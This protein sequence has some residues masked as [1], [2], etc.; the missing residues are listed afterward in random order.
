MHHEHHQPLR[1]VKSIGSVSASSKIGRSRRS[2]TVILPETGQKVQKVYSYFETTPDER[3]LEERLMASRSTTSP[4]P[5]LSEASLRSPYQRFIRYLS[6]PV[7]KGDLKASF[8]Y[9]I[10]SLAVYNRTISDLLGVSDSKHLVCTTVVYFH[11]TRTKGSMI[12]SLIFVC[13]SLGFA[14]TVSVIATYISSLFLT[15]T[16]NFDTEVGDF[17]QLIISCASLGAISFVKLWMNQQT[18]DN[19]CSLS[20]ITVIACIIKEGS[21]GSSGLPWAKI[22]SIFL[23]TLT[24]CV[25][26][27]GTN[28]LL[29]PTSAETN[30]KNS[31]NEN[32]DMLSVLLKRVSQSFLR[33]EN[34]DSPAMNRLVDQHKLNLISLKETLLEAKFELYLTGREYEYQLLE[35][36]VQSANRLAMIRAGLR[37]SVD[38]KWELV[39]QEEAAAESST[40]GAVSIKSFQ[41]D[42]YNDMV[43]LDDNSSE[44][45]IEEDEDDYDDDVVAFDSKELFDL[46]VYHLGPSMKSFSFT[47]R[48]ILASIAFDEKHNVVSLV[49]QFTESLK[50]ARELFDTRQ[51]KAI[52]NLYD[53]ELFKQQTDFDTKLHQE[54]VTASCG[55]FTYLL[56]EFSREL[57]DNLAILNE[58]SK[59]SSH[60]RTF[61]FLKFWDRKKRKNPESTFNGML[62]H[63]QIQQDFSPLSTTL[64]TEE[65]THTFLTACKRKI[66]QIYRLFYGVDVQFGIRVFFGTLVMAIFGYLDSTKE[67]FNG[68]HSE[69]GIVAFCIIMNKS[70]GGTYMT[71][72]WRFFGTFIGAMAGY[73]TWV[74]FYPNRFMMALC[75]FLFALP[76]FHIIL[77]WTYI[78]GYGRFILLAYNLTILYSYTR[79]IG[80]SPDT[81]EGGN[82]PMVFQIGLHRFVG[83]SLGSLWALIVTMTLFPCSARSR[84]RRGLSILWLRMGIVW[85]SG[86]LSYVVDPD[87]RNCKLI[88]IRDRKTIHD[89]MDELSILLT[90]APLE[91]RLKGPFPTEIYSKLLKST[92]KIIDAFENMNS[93]IQ[94]DTILCPNEYSVLAILHDEV[95]E[96]ENRVFLIFYMLAS[97]MKLGFP[98]ANK[99]ASTEH[100]KKRM[101]LKLSE[102]R[103]RI[104]SENPVLTN[105]DF[106]L[107]YSYNLVTN[108][109]IKELDVLL[110]LVAELYGMVSEDTLAM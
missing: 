61:G 35:K 56:L 34:L 3:G 82:D 29:W 81:I 103:N 23:I 1:T 109:V 50:A 73:L 55:N 38:F 90:Q 17:I 10:A 21:V 77:T 85:H 79:S 72:K 51:S 48:Q 22:K 25:C 105:K 11:A 4:L 43:E 19:A 24:G 86:P 36:L 2:S 98:L 42:L 74:L 26:S 45:N 99:P 33:F 84:I 62:E 69:W 27:V 101:L 13:I 78:N 58:L 57:M 15:K 32:M 16:D 92:T 41:S 7:F 87:T 80:K 54:E 68:W 93:V 110:K 47:V 39:H 64:T 97:A 71:F 14:F 53:Q 83:V 46:F 12:Q 6:S 102:V 91:I 89:I 88:G 65:S 106:V 31:L 59:A 18:F 28:W 76:C 49:P 95:A 63:F 108:S 96:L 44:E 8:A 40:T 107:L 52:K 67:Y 100:A 66:W 60:K 75:G 70:V 94:M 30:L 9:F 104:E 37:R 20:A 5:E